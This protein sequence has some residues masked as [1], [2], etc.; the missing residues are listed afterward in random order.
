MVSILPLIAQVRCTLPS[1]AKSTVSS[2]ARA[3]IAYFGSL[4]SSI[5]EM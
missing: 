5:V 4:M 3:R 2:E 1:I